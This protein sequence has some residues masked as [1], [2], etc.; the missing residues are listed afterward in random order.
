MPEIFSALT[1]Y[2]LFILS[3]LLSA[4]LVY[5]LLVLIGLL[6]LEALDGAVDAAA[7]G[8]SFALGLSSRC[9]V[10][11]SILLSLNIFFAWTLCLIGALAL[12]LSGW[13]WGTLLLLLAFA[14]STP[15]SRLAARPLSPI[16]KTKQGVGHDDLIGKVCIITTGSV[17]PTFGQAR[18][19]D[20]SGD[21]LIQ[22]RH[23]SPDA[24]KRHDRALIIDY[25]PSREAFLI[26]PLDPNLREL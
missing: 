9:G 20:T 24:F 8:L 17:S 15:L 12:S 1:Q 26:E 5:W 21:H 19:D 7:D 14:A 18:C 4:C 3:L 23:D 10:P 2:P 22:V 13:L 16:F 11:A 25:D 6:D